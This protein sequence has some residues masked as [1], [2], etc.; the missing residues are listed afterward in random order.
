MVLNIELRLRAP[1]IRVLVVIVKPA[2]LLPGFSIDE[3]G[4]EGFPDLLDDTHLS[5]IGSHGSRH[6]PRL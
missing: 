6:N 1:A 2:P 3:A 4:A 5:A